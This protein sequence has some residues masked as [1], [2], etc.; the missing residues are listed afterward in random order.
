MMA[1]Q[2]MHF[3]AG[4]IVVAESLNK[5][6]RSCPFQ[7][8]M[9]VPQRANELLKIAAW[10]LLALGGAGAVITPLLHLEWSTLHDTSMVLGFSLLLIHRRINED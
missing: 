7:T 2:A 5:L 10:F 3:V 8:G 6:E 9:T 1:I 4:L